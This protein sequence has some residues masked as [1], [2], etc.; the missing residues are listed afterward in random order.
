MMH[1]VDVDP[2]VG[3]EIAGYSIESV[4]GRGAM[5]VVYLA[6]QSS[7]D[8]R[9][10][11][12]LINPAFADDDAFR[13]RFLRESTAAAAIDHPH[14]LPVYAAGEADGTLF[15]AM[16]AVEGRDLREILRMPVGSSTAT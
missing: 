15:I 1:I 5:G 12:K 7:P 13:R 11:L 16:R 9:V 3:R 2:L 6:H 14:I 10:A 4:L 8:R